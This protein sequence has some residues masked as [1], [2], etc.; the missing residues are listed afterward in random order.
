MSSWE[1][2]FIV[3]QL[4][5]GHSIHRNWK[6]FDYVFE[7]TNRKYIPD[8]IV[9]GCYAEVKGWESPQWKAKLE[10]FP[11]PIEV[12]DAKRMEPILKYVIDKYGSNFAED[13]R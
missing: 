3:F 13:L 7:N 4:E 8:F 6:P 11:L 5:H 9:D 10:A 2:A 1:L 12:F